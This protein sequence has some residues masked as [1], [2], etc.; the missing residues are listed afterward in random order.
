MRDKKFLLIALGLILL[1]GAL[2]SQTFYMHLSLNNGSTVLIPFEEVNKITFDGVTNIK[3]IKKFQSVLK[4][5]TIID[6]TNLNVGLMANYPFNGNAND[7]SGNGNHGTIDEVR[8]YKRILTQIEI[9]ALYI[10]F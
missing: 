5:F 10:L 6:T 7:E 1:F 3:D 8:I 2:F 4:T 9:Q